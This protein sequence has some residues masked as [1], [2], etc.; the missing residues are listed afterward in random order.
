MQLEGGKKLTIFGAAEVGG[1]ESLLT[2]LGVLLA[3]Y[4]FLKF[5]SWAKNFELSGQFKK[6]LFILTGIGLIAFNVFYSIGNKFADQGNWN[7]AT[8]ALVSALIWTFIFAFTLMAET[9][10]E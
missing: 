5:C 10:S 6:V 9:K 1:L 7:I 3:I 2:F 4:I 8:L